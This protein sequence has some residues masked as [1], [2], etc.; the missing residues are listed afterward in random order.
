MIDSPSGENL[1]PVGLLLAL[2][3]LLAVWLIYRRR[4]R[5]P[6]N[7]SD[8][9]NAIAHERVENLVIPNGDD[10]EIQI[11]HLLL[12]TK[13]LLVIDIKDIEGIVFGSNK[14]E[15][16]TVIGPKNRFQISNPQPGLYDRIAAIRHIVREVP[17]TGRILFLDGAEFSKGVPEYVCTLQQLHQEFNEADKAAAKFK[18][19]AFRQHWETLQRNAVIPAAASVD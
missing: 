14:M 12:T 1:L 3:A 16:W 15:H 11:D 18:I 8:V 13:G 7:L 4:A 10:G 2:L 5:Q 9:L 19:D 6:L 17:V